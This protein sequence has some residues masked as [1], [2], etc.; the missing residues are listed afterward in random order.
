MPLGLL[1]MMLLYDLGYLIS[2]ALGYV[3]K[4]PL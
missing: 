2:A 1:F 3:Y 4:D